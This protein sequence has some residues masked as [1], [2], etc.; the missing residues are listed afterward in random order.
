MAAKG[1][2]LLAVAD[3]VISRKVNDPS[4]SG[5]AIS[6]TDASGTRYSYAHL[7]AFADGI[8]VGQ[9]VRTGDVV[10]Y[11]G[12]TGDAA[13]G[14]T[15]LHFEVH[16]YGGAA[17][18]PKP[19]VD[20][21][22]D[23]AERRALNL[24]R[25][26]TGKRLT[27]KDLDLTLWKNKLLKLARQEIEA[28]NLQPRP[29]PVEVPVRRGPDQQVVAYTVPVS[30]LGLLAGSLL[31][32]ARMAVPAW[33]WRRRGLSEAG[34]DLVIVLDDLD[35]EIEGDVAAAVASEE[36]SIERALRALA[37]ERT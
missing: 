1:T 33:L 37:N 20:G 35:R 2:P 3:G 22:L 28:S 23:A 31:L 19:Y 30:L 5:L 26:M 6:L 13:G 4:W 24:V 25:R 12:N 17:V 32:L 8:A 14:P 27:N 18:P 34:V 16:P 15:H 9:G 7:S 36:M 10:G 11:V 21:W 29:A